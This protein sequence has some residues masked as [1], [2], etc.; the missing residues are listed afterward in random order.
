MQLKIAKT[1]NFSVDRY[2]YIRYPAVE[3]TTINYTNNT[4][5]NDIKTNDITITNFNNSWKNNKYQ[6][7]FARANKDDSKLNKNNITSNIAD[8][9]K[10]NYTCVGF[11]DCTYRESTTSNRW[12]T[13]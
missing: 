6:N 10:A 5:R 2:C 7:H 1:Y 4:N 13:F 3:Y 11:N 8:F 9:N 12:I